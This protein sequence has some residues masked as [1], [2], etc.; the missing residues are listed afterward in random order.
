MLQATLSALEKELKSYQVRVDFLQRYLDK[1]DESY[2]D[3]DTLE[4]FEAIN[5][6]YEYQKEIDFKKSLIKQREVQ[7]KQAKEQEE[8]KV[9][10]IEEFPDVMN[11]AYEAHS[12]MAK[13]IKVLKSAKRNKEENDFLKGLLSQEEQTGVMLDHIKLRFNKDNNHKQLINDFRQLHEIIKLVS[14]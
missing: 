7:I 9:K 13:D 5:N 14:E 4:A 1:I 8:L 10:C 11:K 2:K 6:A 12:Q 3:K